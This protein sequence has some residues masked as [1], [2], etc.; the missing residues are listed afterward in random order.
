MNECYSDNNCINCS[1]CNYGVP[2]LALCEIC[3]CVAL[4]LIAVFYLGL[5]GGLITNHAT[6]VTHIDS[7][8]PNPKEDSVLIV[9]NAIYST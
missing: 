6:D 4:F 9:C 7:R 5:V 1:C 8:V 3:L 2:Y